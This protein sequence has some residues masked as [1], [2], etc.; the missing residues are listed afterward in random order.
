MITPEQNEII[1]EQPPVG[2]VWLFKAMH[3]PKSRAYHLLH[4]LL[5][6]IIFVSAIIG[7]LETVEVFHTKYAAFFHYSELVIVGIFTLE[8]IAN[9]ITT[10]DKLGYVFSFW[11]MI[12]LLAIMPTYLAMANITALKSTRILRVLRVFLVL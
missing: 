2:P 3:S 8:Y 12:D 11:G 4:G 1:A 6:T 5:N 7:A 10:K 9:L